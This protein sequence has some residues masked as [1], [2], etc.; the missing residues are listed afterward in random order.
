MKSK[1][2]S[3]GAAA[4]HFVPARGVGAYPGNSPIAPRSPHSRTNSA[5]VA[6]YGDV[7]GT[8]AI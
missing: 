5:W 2:L 4:M 7:S 1:L 3:P 8:Q 6:Q